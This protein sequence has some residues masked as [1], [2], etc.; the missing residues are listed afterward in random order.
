M[1]SRR[2]DATALD[3][4]GA[5]FIAVVGTAWHF[6]YAWSGQIALIGWIAPVSESVWEHTKLVAVPSLMWNAIAASRLP[7]RERLAW[8]SFVEAC[9]GPVV[10]VLGFYAYTS[11]LHRGWFVMDIA[12]FALA[13]AS[14]RF[15]NHYT[16]EG[17]RRV[18]GPLPSSLL[19]AALLAG[20]V[21][22]T[23]APPDLPP[24]RLPPAGY[25]DH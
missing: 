2:S 11:V 5:L 18:P 21:V 1:N 15:A 22:L 8:A 24:F 23:I 17:S 4:W 25:Y 10:M 12:V 9:T 20:Y 7:H 14:G 16:R 6:V 13:I 19:I 3:W